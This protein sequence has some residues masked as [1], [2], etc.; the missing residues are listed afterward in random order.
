MK[1]WVFAAFVVL[2]NSL[3][4]LFIAQGMH[5]SAEVDSPLA[6]LTAIFNPMVILGIV[7]LIAWLLTRMAM[8]SW[9]DLTYVL[10]VT[11]FGYVISA[12]L[13]WAFLE[14]TITPVRWA[15]TLLIVAGTVLVG[16]GDPHAERK[17]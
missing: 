14:E 11:A 2:S 8:L 6:M 10:P 7:L 5:A 17:P 9:A 15:G 4:N 3:G 16:M 1:T 13:G 12:I